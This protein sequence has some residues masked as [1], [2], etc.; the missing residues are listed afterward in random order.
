MKKLSAEEFKNIFVGRATEEWM[1]RAGLDMSDPKTSPYELDE[2]DPDSQLSA[3]RD[4]A[5]EAYTFFIDTLSHLTDL[6]YTIADG[7]EED[8]VQDF[9]ADN[10]GNGVRESSLHSATPKP[11]NVSGGIVTKTNTTFIFMSPEPGTPRHVSD[12]KEWLAE[13]ES[14]GVP[15]TEEVEGE[16]FLAY[17]T[18]VLTSERSECLYCENKEDILLTVHDCR[19][20]EE[21]W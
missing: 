4:T 16:L 15:E 2:S 20:G 9:I 18:A 1:R 8:L 7:D 3:W 12:V 13:V 6:G 10:L 14:L 19:A 21:D 5:E 17:D 11:T